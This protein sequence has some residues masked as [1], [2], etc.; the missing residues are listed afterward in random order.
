MRQ[1]EAGLDWIMTAI[2]QRLIELGANRW[3]LEVYSA[4]SEFVGGRQGQ[5]RCFWCASNRRATRART[6]G[7]KKI[8]SFTSFA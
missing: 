7:S 8:A 6:S 1:V 3:V 5:F 4:T 2:D